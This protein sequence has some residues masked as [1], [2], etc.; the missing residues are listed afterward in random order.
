MSVWSLAHGGRKTNFKLLIC[1]IVLLMLLLLE[2]VNVGTGF[3]TAMNY[4]AKEVLIPISIVRDVKKSVAIVVVV[5][6]DHNKEQYQQAQDTIECYAVHH[7]YTF[8]YVNV[9]SNA[10]LS[11]TCPQ[12]DFMFQRH[13]VVAELMSSWPEEW[14]L[15]LDADMA[16]INPNHLIE[17]YIPSD[18]DIHI[19]F[20]KRIFN[21]EVMAGSYL[22][23]NSG[24]SRKFLTHWSL[25][26]FSLPKSFHG[27][28]NG[29]IHSVIASFELPELRKVR[30]KCEELW[31]ASKDFN[32]LSFYEVCMQLIL[33]S[34]PLK[35]ILI[36]D[37]GSN[38]WARDG[39]LTNSAWCDKDFILHGWQKKRKDKM[40]FARWHSP[41]VDRVWN[42]TLC[43]TSEAYL[44]WRYKDSFIEPTEAIQRRLYKVIKEVDREFDLIKAAL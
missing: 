12:K 10:T 41:L 28:D 20:Y 40:Q 19:V 18:P 26:E 15:F 8:Y 21:H 7:R 34:N 29:A 25:Y 5:Q 31:A 17:E 13:C 35:H 9:H 44:N 36:I 39:W 27:S 4:Y 14:L 38:S 24:L 23:R 3:I 22:I 43:R 32:S 42:K 33:S 16:V 11:S 2:E 37:K 30:E 6:N 1:I